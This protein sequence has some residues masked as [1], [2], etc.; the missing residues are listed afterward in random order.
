MKVSTRIVSGFGVLLLVAVGTLGYQVYVIYQ[1]QAVNQTL[2][3]LNFSAARLI[4]QMEHSRADVKD[5]GSKYFVL[6]GDEVYEEEV[7]KLKAELSTDIVLLRAKAHTSRE[8]ESIDYLSKLWTDFWTLWDVEK[9][10]INVEKTKINLESDEVPDMPA[11]LMDS[12]EE[13]R[14]QTDSALLA[15]LASIQEQVND[16]AI[17]GARARKI[18]FTAGGASLLIALIV[19]IYLVRAIAD[20]LRQVT[21]GTR[22]ISKGQFWHRLPADSRDEFGELARDFN[23]MAQRLSELDQMKKDFVSH[24]SHELKAPLASMRQ[25]FLLLLQEIAGPLNEQQRKLLRLS[26]ISAE[27]L[28]SMVGNLLDVSRLEAGNMEYDIHAFDV[29]P[30]VHSVAEEFE[31]QAQEKGIKLQ[32]E[33]DQPAW[34]QCDRDRIVQVIGNLFENALKFAPGGTP[35]IAR[36]RTEDRKVLV[37]LIDSGTG[38]ANEHKTRIFEKF[39]QVKRGKKISGQ[40]VGLGL[41]ICKTII[42]A[43][44]GNIWVEDN[45]GGGSIFSFAL[46][47]AVPT[48]STAADSVVAGQTR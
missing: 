45:P 43:H 39:H 15:V 44:N 8:H 46:L 1:M 29:A 40:G 3:D 5:L 9:T 34:A 22:R 32:V 37:S 38:V 17:S 11:T 31:V 12:L 27:R 30:L 10:K 21:Q 33:A 28:T 35:I 41:A 42:D 36:V 26:S 25:V 16:A 14:I 19:A 7:E 2:S 4:Q 47:A 23:A 13:I 20:P 18:S 6:Q 24:V 48:A